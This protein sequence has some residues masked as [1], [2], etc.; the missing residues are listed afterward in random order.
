M[1]TDSENRT[2]RG[3]KKCEQGQ[4]AR[5][6][7]VPRDGGSILENGERILAGRVRKG[8]VSE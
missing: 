8:F 4:K 5:Q 1:G 6:L 7:M 3:L 2:Q